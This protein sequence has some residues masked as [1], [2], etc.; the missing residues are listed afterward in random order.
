MLIS[1]RRWNLTWGG[2]NHQQ[3]SKNRA[4]MG[5]T[6]REHGK[7]KAKTRQDH[8]KKR[9]KDSAR[10]WQR[11]SEKITKGPA[12]QPRQNRSKGEGAP[13]A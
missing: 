3:C 6:Q 1:Q 2:V 5:R 4:A 9:D 11:H 13:R 8:G 10:A 7:G 12:S